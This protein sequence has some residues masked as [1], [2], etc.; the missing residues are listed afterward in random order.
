MIFPKKSSFL[1]KNPPMVKHNFITT[2]GFFSKH[3]NTAIHNKKIKMGLPNHRARRR[4]LIVFIVPPPVAW[5]RTRIS[6][7][8][9]PTALTHSAM[10]EATNMMLIYAVL[11]HSQT[12]L[13]N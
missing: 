2:G 8:K 10:K 1:K 5:I 6:G 12:P 3:I 13:G 11:F 7:V 4:E 9:R